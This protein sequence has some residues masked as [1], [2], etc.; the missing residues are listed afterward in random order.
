[1]SDDMTFS[2]DEL[3]AELRARPWTAYNL[4]LADDVWTNPALPDFFATDERLGAITRTIHAFFGSDLTRLR[5]ADLGCLE[6]GFSLALA[7]S[8]A[9]VIGFDAREEN[10]I[11]ARFVRDHFGL[12]NL[13]Y[14]CV[15]VKAFSPD[16][17]GRFDVVLVLGLLYHLDE[18]VEWLARI[19]GCATRLLIVDTHVAPHDSTVK[20]LHHTIARVGHL[21]RLTV[22]GIAYLGRWFRELERGRDLRP[23]RWAAWSNERSFW[24][25]RESLFRAMRH[26]GFG[27]VYEQQDWMLDQWDAYNE[28]LSRRL[29]IGVKA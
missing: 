3:N 8:G 4:K 18:P 25:T 27:L 6:G 17:N 24:L 14:E 10:L 21:E 26:A 22:D 20:K 1:M 19:A 7:R 11:R 16:V 15:D 9:E 23:E 5:I 28:E 12:G 13:R 2:K 29:V